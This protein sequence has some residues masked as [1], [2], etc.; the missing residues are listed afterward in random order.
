MI[1]MTEDAVAELVRDLPRTLGP[2]L[3]V[4]RRAVRTGLPAATV[5]DAAV[6]VLRVI[7]GEP[8]LSVGRVA[9][10]IGVAANTVSTLVGELVESGLVERHRDPRD[11][12]AASL[13]LTEEARER[14]ESWSRRRDEVLTAALGRLGEQECDALREALPALR[15]LMVAL[16]E[17]TQE[18]VA[19]MSSGTASDAVPDQE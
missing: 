3:R 17:G 8:G 19:A 4:S 16:D 2:F 1:G 9:E 14:L 12:R 15:S 18:R 11:R 5:R 7:E 10:L 13:H 6:E